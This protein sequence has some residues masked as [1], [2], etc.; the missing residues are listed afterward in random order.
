[1]IRLQSIYAVFGKIFLSICL[2]VFSWGDVSAKVSL[3]SIFGDNMVLQ[4]NSEVKILGTTGRGRKVRM[5][6]SWSE[7]SQ[8]IKA[9]ENGCFLFK[10]RTPSAG[11]PYKITFDDG[12]VVVLENILIGEVW[13]CS[14][15]SNM[16]MPVRGLLNQPVVGSNRVIAQADPQVP[17]RMF[18]VQKATAKSPTT[19]C[20]G[21]W[22]DNA[23]THVA[24]FSAV[25]YFFGQYLQRQLKVPVGLIHTSWGA[26][27][28]QAWMSEEVLRGIPEIN[29]DHLTG[30]V[31]TK[32]LP[33][34][35]PCLLYN[36]MIYPLKDYVI[37]GA[38]W[39]QGESN[40]QNPELYGKLF[41]AFV[42][43]LRST[44][45][46]GDFPFYYAQIAP[47]PLA[48]YESAR[49]REVQMHSVKSIA[50]S[51][52]AVLMDIGEQKCIHPSRKMEVGERLAYW[53]LADTYGKKG[54]DY[55]SPEYDSMEVVKGKVRL[56]FRN[57]GLGLTSYYQ[58]LKN[59]EIAGEDKVFYPAKAY[60]MK[61]E[62]KVYVEVGSQSVANPVA[63]RYAFKSFA[64]GDLF[65]VTGLPVSSFRT[66]DWEM[67]GESGGQP[68]AD[69]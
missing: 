8:T 60:I 15:Q 49:L 9:D 66:D 24:E 67:A 27:N 47:F 18:T 46:Q 41:P 5:R 61:H 11:G 64:V 40:V 59:F 69:R 12:D 65:G 62:N 3:P 58:E 22:V 17:I 50:R 54:F 23:S 34:Q 25:G 37:R 7:K 26:S 16:Q 43:D 38:I 33:Q 21:S 13:L 28:V 56:S 1:M 19:D 20:T 45:A 51:G 55:A 39:Y 14:G 52:M 6:V 57:A 36:A 32:L 44:F 35:L 31:E 53:A 48:K 42:S 63:V 10:V 30:D 4:Q 29:L 2:V 68:G